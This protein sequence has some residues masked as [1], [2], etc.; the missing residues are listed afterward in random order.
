MSGIEIP[1]AVAVSFFFISGIYL[2]LSL[3]LQQVVIGF[4]LL[5][6]GVNLLI[7]AASG[8]SPESVE[9][10]LGTDTDKI[11]T[12]PLPQAFVL[13]AIVIGLGTGVFLLATA[14]SQI[15]DSK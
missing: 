14:I 15:R 11:F 1:A 6:N 5:S 2:M 10:I 9:P 3:N 13:T 4:L 8:F 7:L 12:D